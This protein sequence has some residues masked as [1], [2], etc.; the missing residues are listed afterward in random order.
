M[1]FPGQACELCRQ[2]GGA[3][4][5]QGPDCRVIRVDDAGYPGFCRVIWQA[6]VQEM[7]DLDETARQH[8]MRIVFAVESVI[9]T[10]F[11]PQKINLA[12]LG[13]QVPHLHWH[14]IPR[15]SDDPCFPEPVWAAPQRRENP[16]RPV[17]SDAALANA[18]ADALNPIAFE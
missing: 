16:P 1:K 13:N 7:S 18:L 11:S 9:R 8:L 12:S 14:I 3:L 15:W 10:L 17:V 4:L 5:W 6:H 2:A